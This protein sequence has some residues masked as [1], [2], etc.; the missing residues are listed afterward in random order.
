MLNDKGGNVYFD[1]V[2]GPSNIKK[3]N[4][5]C[6]KTAGSSFRGKTLSFAR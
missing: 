3:E 5:K 1:D 4:L 2:V 6:V